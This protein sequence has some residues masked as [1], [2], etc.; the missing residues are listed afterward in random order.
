MTE[1]DH[2]PIS[3]RQSGEDA[4]SRPG[5]KSDEGHDSEISGLRRGLEDRLRDLDSIRP[6]QA[7]KQTIPEGVD[8]AV[9]RN[10]GNP[11]S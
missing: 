7:P 5:M 10:A 1:K 2:S 6:A 8:A 11:V 3:P 4:L 9:K